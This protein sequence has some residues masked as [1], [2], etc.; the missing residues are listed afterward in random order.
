MRP[1]PRSHQRASVAI[2]GMFQIDLQ[3]VD[4]SNE[5]G[6]CLRAISAVRVKIWPILEGQASAWC[7]IWAWAPSTAV[8]RGKQVHAICVSM[9]R[10]PVAIWL[11]VSRGPARSYPLDLS[12]QVS[13]VPHSSDTDLLPPRTAETRLNPKMV[14][15]RRCELVVKAMDFLRIEQHR[16]DETAPW[17]SCATMAL[18][19]LS[20]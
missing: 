5:I 14:L 11:H 20:A 9:G 18:V 3:R 17:Q 10:M 1:L 13:L 16:N 2:I 4:G 12:S 6:K 15:T 7:H 8:S 19:N